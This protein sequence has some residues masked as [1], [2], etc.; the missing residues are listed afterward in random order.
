MRRCLIVNG[1]ESDNLSTRFDRTA[2]PSKLD[3]GLT[4]LIDASSASDSMDEF[5]PAVVCA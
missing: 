3:R 1:R 5:V 2:S 4:D